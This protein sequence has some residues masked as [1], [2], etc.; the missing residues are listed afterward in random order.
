MKFDVGLGFF[1]AGLAR[2]ARKLGTEQSIASTVA[3]SQKAPSHETPSPDS[4]AVPPF[5]SSSE[6]E[7]KPKN[8]KPLNLQA[9]SVTETVPLRR[10]IFANSRH[11]KPKDKVYP[12]SYNQILQQIFGKLDIHQR[13][14]FARLFPT[15]K[16][17]HKHFKESTKYKD[18]K[19]RSY[20]QFLTTPT[21]DTSGTCLL[22]HFDDKRY[23]VGNIHEGFS[24]PAYS[25]GRSSQGFRISL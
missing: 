16:E 22:L 21:A 6:D 20:I 13:A 7:P 8:D 2:V 17:A 4:R 12:S 23:L 5:S 18:R 15:L 9:D 14:F 19:M 25:S 3:P 1:K 10:P 24:A 11:I